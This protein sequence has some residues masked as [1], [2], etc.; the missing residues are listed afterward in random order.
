MSFGRRR[1][2]TITAAAAG[3]TLLSG[4]SRA[5][6]PVHWRGIALGADASITLHHPDRGEAGRLLGLC[7]DEIR[8]LEGVFSLQRPDSAVARLNRTRY[9]STPP[10]ELR[11][12]ASRALDVTAA[13]SGAFDVTVQ[14]LW[15][16]YADYFSGPNAGPNGP[17]PESVESALSLVGKGLSLRANGIT[18]D[19]PG[20]AVTFNG[21]AQGYITDRVVGLLRRH[22]V[23]R[24][25]VDLGEIRVLGAHPAGR[26]WRTGIR[27]PRDTSQIARVVPLFD[28]ALATSG[29][30]GTKFDASGRHHHLFDPVTGRS[31]HYYLDVSVIAPDATTA[32]A[33]STG[34]SALPVDQALAC[35][36][37]FDGVEAHFTLPDGHVVVHG[38]G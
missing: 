4:S 38:K 32:D 26:P 27:D 23:P 31:A 7:H 6:S 25:Y 18:L 16:L 2:L 19:R 35:V 1:F 3:S 24:A 8:R 33:L 36:D 34:I 14:P 9:L 30:Y 21:I 13:T 29:G 5:S 12:L 22:G 15:Q 17:S 11:S 10:T 37:E 20:M 28:R